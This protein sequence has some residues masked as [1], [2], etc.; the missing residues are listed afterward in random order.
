MERCKEYIKE[1]K[2]TKKKIISWM[3]V[4]EERNKITTS[5][6]LSCHQCKGANLWK[7]LPFLSS[8]KGA[9]LWK[10]W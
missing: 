5:T 10:R 9:N 7:N 6:Y 3:N 1:H 8:C 2:Y 4:R